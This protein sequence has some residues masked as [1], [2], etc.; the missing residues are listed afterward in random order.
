[1]VVDRSFY[2]MRIAQRRKL[3]SLGSLRLSITEWQDTGKVH[4]PRGRH[5][6]YGLRWLAPLV[7]HSIETDRIQPYPS[8][9]V[10][11]MVHFA[12]GVSPFQGMLA[13]RRSRGDRGWLVHV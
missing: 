11:F 10:T 5:Y 12:A 7:S 1:M 4:L 13:A 2:V 8:G 6:R 9:S 3:S